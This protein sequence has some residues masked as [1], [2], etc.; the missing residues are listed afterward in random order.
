MDLLG[1]FQSAFRRE[2]DLFS[3]SSSDPLRFHFNQ[4]FFCSVDAEI[5]YCMIRHFKPQKM[6]EVG[7]GM[8]TLLAAEALRKNEMEGYPCSLTAI[9]PHPPE[10]LRR[11]VPGFTVAD[12]RRFFCVQTIS[13]EPICNI[14]RAIAAV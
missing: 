8:S 5:L 6:I 11:G 1:T 10:F 12:F 13:K 4:T 2:Y 3:R 7:S 14:Y 9:E